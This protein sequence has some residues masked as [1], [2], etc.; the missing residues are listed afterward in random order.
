MVEA[1]NRIV[2]AYEEVETALLNVSSRKQQKQELIKQI[3]NLRV[4]RNVQYAQL[5]EGLV[6]QLE[7]FETDRSLLAA[8]QSLL[9]THQQILSDMVNLYKALGGGWPAEVVSQE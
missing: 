2:K 7:V 9:S 8:Q 6:S 1:R 4:V 5:E 3:E